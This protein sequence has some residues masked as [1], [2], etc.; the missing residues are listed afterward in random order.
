[1][2]R[3]SKIFINIVA[4]LMLVVATFSLTACEDIKVLNVTVSVY[5]TTSKSYE[6][7]TIKV[8][9]YRHLAPKTVDAVIDAVKAGYYNDTMIYRFYDNYSNQYM[10]GDLKYVD[11][12]IKQ[13]VDMPKVK[14]EFEYNGVKGSNLTSSKGSI[15]IWRSWFAEDKDYKTSSTARDSGRAVWYMP[16]GDISGYNGYFSVFAQL[17]LEDKDTL[18]LFTDLSSLFG[19]TDY[20][21]TYTVYYTGTENYTTDDNVKNNGLTYNIVKSTD[22][23][24]ADIEDLFKAKGG[25]YVCYNHYT[26]KVPVSNKTVETKK[27]LGAKIVSIE[28]A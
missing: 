12:E 1:M 4:V 25:Q 18:E 3:L 17:N 23:V 6:E 13:N 28:V 21:E 2:K 24:E 7:K 11:G 10:I 22:F 14:G 15:G 8:D 5:D 9:L 19:S 26:I 27:A 20:Y 16:D